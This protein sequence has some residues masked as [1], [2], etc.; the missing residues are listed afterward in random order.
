M[1]VITSDPNTIAQVAQ[2]KMPTTTTATSLEPEYDLAGGDFDKVTGKWVDTFPTDY[3]SPTGRQKFLDGCSSA[4]INF[5]AFSRSSWT[6]YGFSTSTTY[7]ETSGWIFWSHTDVSTNTETRTDTKITGF[8][9][10][11]DITVRWWGAKN[12]NIDY[13]RQVP[14]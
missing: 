5:E 7:N 8:D 6:D 13:G 9:L 2:G 4:T 1:S 10:Q 12:F 11:S 3:P 14:S